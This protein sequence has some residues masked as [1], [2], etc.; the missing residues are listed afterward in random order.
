[1]ILPIH[2]AI[3]FAAM[4]KINNIIFDLGGIFIEINYAKT[5]AAF[6]NL[7]V[8]NFNDLY[9]QHHASPIFELLETG[10]LEPAEFF[11]RFRDISKIHLS[12]E[13]IKDAW[14][15]MLGNFYLETLPWLKE[16]RSKYNIFLYSNTNK[17]HYD[18]IMEI[19]HGQTQQRNFDDYFMK[20]YYSHD[21]G[22]RKPYKEGF[23]KILEEQNLKAEETL[24]IDDTIKNV[25]GAEKAGLQTIHLVSPK[26]VLDLNL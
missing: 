12:D 2:L 5:E 10:K 23:Q 25:E 7:G 14:N 18:A 11:Q 15:A 19:F 16:I 8:T 4:S 3:S 20:A 22:L 1:M 13:E 21:I 24:F 17:I 26:T 9:T 6:V